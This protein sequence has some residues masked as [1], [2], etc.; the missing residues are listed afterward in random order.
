MKLF[1]ALA[2][3][4]V[5]ASFTQTVSAHSGPSETSKA[6]AYFNA[7]FNGVSGVWDMKSQYDEVLFYWH[8]TLMDAFY[9]KDGDLI[10]TFHHVENT[11]LPE[12]ARRSIAKDYK[13][14]IL[15][16]ASFMDKP[17]QASAYYVTV[18]SPSRIIIL[19]IS[20]AGEVSLFKTLR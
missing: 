13:G 4:V 8:G 10:G 16:G 11:E 7:N 9:T 19:E 2:L 15:E 14:Y 1:F 17:G 18:K 5:A 20:A 12:A 3:A 6:A